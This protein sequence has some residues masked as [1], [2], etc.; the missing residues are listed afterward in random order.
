MKKDDD[1]EMTDED[2]QCYQK[3]YRD[4]NGM[5]PKAHY[6][7]IGQEQGGLSSCAKKVTDT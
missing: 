3:R 5:D 4:L 2:A 7:E 6:L 1:F